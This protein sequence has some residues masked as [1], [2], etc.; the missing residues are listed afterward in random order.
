M[1]HASADNIDDL[2]RVVFSRLLSESR[3]NNRV[4]STKG[5]STEVF[6]ALLRLTN[7][8]ARLGRSVDRSRI[9][10]AIG[11][12]T[13]YLSGSSELAHV[14]HYIPA[15]S[16]F[17]EDKKTLGG[18]YGPRIFDP[19]RGHEDRVFDDEWHRVIALLK[20][21]SGSRNAV[22]QIY[23]NA[24][25][26]KDGDDI[27]CTCTLQFAIRRSR[28]EM[29]V[30]MRS[31]DAFLGLPHDFFAFT[32]MQEIAARELGIEIGK[33]HHSVASLHLYD[34]D[35]EGKVRARTRAQKYL[36]EGLFEKVPMP[37]M[38]AGDPWPSIRTLLSSERELRN[39]LDAYVPP[40]GLP[41]YW[42]DLATLLRV[43]SVALADSSNDALMQLLSGM[44]FDGYHLYILDRM[45]KRKQRPTIGDLFDGSADN[46]EPN[47]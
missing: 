29:H 7:P 30:H 11:E 39:N 35:P 5:K 26:R 2:M 18:A 41:P 25:G 10:S 28:L 1:F 27:P 31:N 43:H 34:D 19:A 33:Y 45:A 17:S 16:E 32:M 9:Y 21:R 20:D 47:P 4:E 12:L 8:R 15:Y 44:H 38:P 37:A 46:V 42:E 36:E 3:D 23:S 13:W 22:I 24:D 6:G 40:V 14:E